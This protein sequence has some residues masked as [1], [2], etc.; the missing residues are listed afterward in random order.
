MSVNTIRYPLLWIINQRDP[1]DAKAIRNKACKK[2]PRLLKFR[3][4]LLER[5]GPE[6][7]YSL[8]E[9][10]HE[11]GLDEPIKNFLGLRVTSTRIL[12]IKFYRRSW[13]EVDRKSVV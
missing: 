9:H 3:D 4:W 12:D 2:I 1:S 8:T 13:C 10:L 6:Y 7:R 5:Y 11:Y